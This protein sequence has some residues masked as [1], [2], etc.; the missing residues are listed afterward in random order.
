VVLARSAA[1]SLSQG[2]RI[3]TVGLAL[4][5]ALNTPQT[6]AKKAA[7]LLSSSGRFA[8][9]SP[10]FR[11]AA[12]Q[13]SVNTPTQ[14]MNNPTTD[15]KTDTKTLTHLLDQ[16]AKYGCEYRNGLSDHLPM[17]LHSLHVLGAS[18]ARLHAYA[19]MYRER[20]QPASD[21]AI[22]VNDWQNFRGRLDAYPALANYFARRLEN[23][24]RDVVLL[25][26]VPVLLPGVAAGAFHGLIRSGHAI[27]ANHNGEL[28][29]GLAYWT[30]RYQPLV[31][32]SQLE[33]ASESLLSLESWLVSAYELARSAIPGQQR[34]MERMAAWAQT[35]AF[36]VTAPRLGVNDSTLQ[37]IARLA[38]ALY[39]H[40]G[41]F[42]VLHMLTSTHAMHVMRPHFTDVLL[43]TRWFAIAVFAAIRA[44]GVTREQLT[45]A[46]EATS[47]E[48]R[49]HSDQPMSWNEIAN[50]AI[51]SDDDH[52]A[53]LVYSSKALFDIYGDQVFHAAAM[54]GLVEG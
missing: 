47:T 13:N 8:N 1:T 21:C 45:S 50:Q 54:R 5:N 51:A 28:A 17:L 4:A 38:A 25:D 46:L 7:R 10:H 20:L 2:L 53:K 44:A 34:I 33:L 49:H 11:H 15:T 6:V 24:G 36:G 37:E 43:A 3:N 19:A 23:E 52:M 39:A 48:I 27:A 30:A 14:K 22:A 40:T 42:T 9:P 41:N 32:T 16:S 29:R 26:V 31:E 18:D 35:E 12:R